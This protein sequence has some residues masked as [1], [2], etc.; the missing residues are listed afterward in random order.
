[1]NKQP[2]IN[3]VV[4][5]YNEEAIFKTLQER[6][7]NLMNDSELLISVIMIDDGSHDNTPALI[8]ELSLN[9]SRFSGIF[10]SRNFGHQLALSA[11][12]SVVN[13]SEGVFIIDGDLQDPPELLNNFYKYLKEG[14]DVV[15]AI[16]EKR[17]ESFLLKFA[18]SS[19]YK[20]LHKISY[21]NIPIDSGDFSLIS[22]RVADRIV[23]MREESRFIRGMRTWVGYKQI[24]VPYER[25]KRYAGDSKYSLTQ[26]IKLAFNG[27]FNFSEFPIR[28]IF[29][30]G[31]I[32]T[33]ISL[34]YILYALIK[35]IFT[36]TVPEGFIGIICTITLF[37]GIQLLSIG[38]IGE[39][40]IRIFFQVKDR[41][42]FIIEK[43]IKNGEIIL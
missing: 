7:T 23:N 42:L 33:S 15:Y 34:L 41:P 16:R 40:I 36:N 6:L 26:L 2:Q 11:G 21:I 12:L 10:L 39:Y 24:G 18:Y 19:F 25:Q 27:I 28:L 3:I 13:A 9:D 29:V 4:P 8:E 37:G 17:K 20:I 31:V 35:M 5:L 32:T 1:M 43:Q 22:R 30:L 14:Y 38:I